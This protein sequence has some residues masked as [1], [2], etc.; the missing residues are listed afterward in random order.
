MSELDNSQPGGIPVTRIVGMLVGALLLAMTLILPAPAGMSDAAWKASG[1]MLLLAAWW[2]TEALPIPATSLL[3]IVL[4]P[5]LGLGTVA[6]ATAPYANQVIFLF[7]GGFVLGLA[8][9]RWNLHKRIA[10]A[11]LLAVGSK[12]AN[13]I[14]GFMIATAFISMWVSNTATAIMMLPIGL[15]VVSMYDGD[16]PEAVRKYAVALLLGI[17]YAASIGGIGTLI[18]TPPNALLAGF[19]SSE[20]DIQIGFA[21]WMLIGVPIALTMLWWSG[22]CCPGRTSA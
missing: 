7:M 10:L 14:G 2:S 16:Q 13:Q 8:M 17:A 6:Q 18:G 12:P 19:L 5:A 3:P 4:I 9:Q 15:S 21:Q 22:S 20:Y 11:V 1:L